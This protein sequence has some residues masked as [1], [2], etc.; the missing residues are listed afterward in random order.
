MKKQE[1]EDLMDWK[2]ISFGHINKFKETAETMFALV[3]RVLARQVVEDYKITGGSCVD[4]GAGTG[5]FACEIAKISNMTVYALDIN[6]EMIEIMNEKIQKEGL[7]RRVI[8]TFGDVHE[9]PFGSNFADLI[10]SRG[11][12]PFWKDKRKAFLEIHRVLKTGG[13]GFIG[14]GFGRDEEVRKK[15]MKLH[16]EAVRN[17]SSGRGFNETLKIRYDE[18]HEILRNLPDFKI[19]F[20]ESGLWVEIRKQ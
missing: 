3:Y 20:D 18:L 19:I 13:V 7:K 8:P 9:L 17:M 11:S 5:G 2:N 1:T 16:E 6:H 12:F 15:V 14:G 10:V 4:I